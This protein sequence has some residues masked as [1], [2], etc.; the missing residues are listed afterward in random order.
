MPDFGGAPVGLGSNVDPNKG[1]QTLSGLLSLQQQRQ[2]LQLQSQELQRSQV[3]TQQQLGA[4]QFFS[5]VPPEAFHG[6]DGTI[7]I[8]KI[9]SRPEYQA[10]SGAARVMVDTT[11]NNIR[12]QQLDNKTKLMNLSDG[13][14]SWLGK[15]AEAGT[16]VDPQTAQGLFESGAELNPEYARAYSIYKPGLQAAQFHKG[17]LNN[18]ATLSTD[19]V[20][21]RPKPGAIE[22]P[23]NI[24]PTTTEPA[25]GIQTP[26]GQ[27]VPK[28]LGAQMATFPNKT[29]GQVGGP[30]TGGAL[31]N[32]FFTPQAAAGGA[33]AAP[34]GPGPGAAPPQAPGRSSPAANP[35]DRGDGHAWTAKDTM[36]ERND[37]GGTQEL[38]TA[39]S[40][41]AATDV[42]GARAADKDYGTNMSLADTIRGLVR[43]GVETGPG[44]STWN[45]IMGGVGARFGNNN[46]AN[47]QQL[48]A[49]LE[50]QSSRLQA[51]MGL[52][53]TNAGLQAAQTIGGHTGYQPQAIEAKNDYLQSLIEGNHQY[54]QMLDRVERFTGQPNPQAVQSAKAAFQANFDPRVYEGEMAYKRSKADG[55]KFMA[56]LSPQEAQS[57]AAKRAALQKLSQGQMP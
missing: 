19:V 26:T 37:P 9:H 18:I 22:T 17:A 56:T 14:V 50:N 3:Q 49:F 55:D 23:T 39:A 7:D 25:T 57:L 46:I 13:A 21:N 6:D 51:S 31:G 40:Q 44:T 53:E 48:G 12:G 11:A 27:N 28:G 24:Y 32:N 1:I 41:Q 15:T 29:I 35:F 43:G 47:Y 54:R 33:G 4:N 8:D 20:S 30:T 52:P 45:S 34:R 10:L 2:Q 16:K 42:A 36:P 38:Y 5:A